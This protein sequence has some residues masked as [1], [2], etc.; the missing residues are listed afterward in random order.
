MK[1]LFGILLFTFGLMLL[2]IAVS[3]GA[4]GTWFFKD[5]TETHQQQ[6]S[7]VAGINRIDIE[8]PA[9][10]I[11]I[12]P[13]DRDDLQAAVQGERDANVG[14]LVHQEKDALKVT[15]TQK[16]SRWFTFSDSQKITVRIPQDY[17]QRMSITSSSGTVDMEGPSANTPFVLRELAVHMTSGETNLKNLQLA[18]LQYD[19]SSGDLQVEQVKAETAV[20]S[21]SSGEITLTR[22]SGALEATLS[23]GDLRAQLDAV[24]APIKIN[25]SSGE[26][27]L[28]IPEDAH[29]TLNG[30]VSSGDIRCDLPLLGTQHTADKHS[31]HG[32]SG[33]GTHPIDII[34]QSGDVHLY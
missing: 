17:H 15:M 21:V 23:S 4:A 31:L 14:I 5:K 18:T 3:V 7:S 33:K 28:D 20:I 29:F 2:F 25:V 30:Q 13:E 27:A 16:E 32:S 11:H 1:K 22:Y 9:A 8:A 6:T 10:D 34:V 26:A 24:T 12:I 19:G